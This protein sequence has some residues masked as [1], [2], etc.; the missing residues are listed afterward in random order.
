MQRRSLLGSA[1]AALFAPRLARAAN[2]R[3]GRLLLIGGAEDRA[4]D[5]V[6]LRRFMSLSGGAEAPIRFI[7]AAS[8]DPPTVWRSYSAAFEDMGARDCAHI[9]IGSPEDAAQPEVVA[10]ILAAR[11]VFL[12]GGDQSRLM[13]Y[14]WRTP[15]SEAIH[16]AFHEQGCCIAGTSAGAAVMS[17]F[18][19]AQGAAVIVPEKEAVEMDVGLGLL[20]GAVVDQHFSQRRRLARLLSA[21]AQRPEMLGVGVDEDTA[22]LVEPGQGIEIIGRSSVT[23]IDCSEMDSNFADADE[24]DKLELHGVRLHMLPSGRRYDALQGAGLRS[25][26]PSGLYRAVEKLVQVGPMR[27]F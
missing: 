1:L 18:M 12:T 23:I 2:E 19:L 17:R 16:T 8:A 21:L 24:T 7:T 4:Q 11:G 15:A 20:P 13:S 6:I 27:L 9:P 3:V 22:L 26:D 5:R 14:L 10:A 25:R